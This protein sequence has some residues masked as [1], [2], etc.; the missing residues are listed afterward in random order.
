MPDWAA[1]ALAGLPEVMRGS[2]SRANAVTRACV[3][4]A[5]AVLLAPHVG[6]GFAATVLRGAEGRRKAEVFVEHPAILA[7][8]DGDPPEGAAVRVRLAR[9][10]PATRAV[11]FAYP[12]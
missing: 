10:D 1:Q 9:A 2:G 4:L 3:D 6:E 11:E 8:C 12:A 5:E 7:R